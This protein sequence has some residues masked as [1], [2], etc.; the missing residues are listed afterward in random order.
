MSQRSITPEMPLID[1]G[2]L[3]T[4]RASDRRTVAKELADACRELGFFY[5]KNHGISQEQ[6]DGM[7]DLARE[8]HALPGGGQARG[9]DHREEPWT[10]FAA[11]CPAI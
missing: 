1:L 7:F 8:F 9:R 10:A 2:L 4:G 6:I 5:I 11:I 3:N